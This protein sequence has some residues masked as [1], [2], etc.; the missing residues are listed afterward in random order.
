MPAL[1]GDLF[2]R[3]VDLQLLRFPFPIPSVDHAR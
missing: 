3:I 2:G 1:I